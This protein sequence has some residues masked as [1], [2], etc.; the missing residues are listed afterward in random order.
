MDDEIFL[1]MSSALAEDTN[2][3]DGAIFGQQNMLIFIGGMELLN[4]AM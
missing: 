3:H 1:H 2:H 4:V